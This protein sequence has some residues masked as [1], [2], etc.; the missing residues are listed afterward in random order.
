MYWQI[1][2]PV[3]A[4]GSEV[5]YQAVVGRVPHRL[6]HDDTVDGID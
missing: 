2:S 6:H 5:G 4:G 3:K 1:I